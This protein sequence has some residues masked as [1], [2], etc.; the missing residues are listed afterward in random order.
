MPNL[1]QLNHLIETEAETL[2]NILRHY[3][4]KAG[5][6]TPLIVKSA[7]EE[8]FNEV[9]VEVLSHPERLKNVREP[10]AWM[11]GVAANLIRRQCAAFE[12][13]R[14]MLVRDLFSE[15]QDDMSDSDLFDL[16]SELAT[17]SPDKE[18]ESQEQVRRLLAGMSEADQTVLRLAVLN[19]LNGEMLAVALHTTPGAARVRL[20][21]ALARLRVVLA[22]KNELHLEHWI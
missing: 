19:D 18:V 17:A 20:H 21:R 5:L 11:L 6:A 10:T 16:L 12:R 9:V 15:I 2:Q 8:L 1:E 13:Q 3:L 7:A 22:A 14:E 4:L